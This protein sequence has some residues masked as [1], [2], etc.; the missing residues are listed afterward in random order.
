MLR[1]VLLSYLI[2]SCPNAYLFGRWFGGRDVRRVGSRNVGATNVVANVGWLA[3]A[4]TL[5]G[6]LGKGYLA[7]L[8][9]GPSAD[10]VV[11][12]LA[13]AFAIAG[14]N[15]PVW[16]GFHGGGGLATFVGACLRLNGW[17][18]AVAAL[19]LWGLV[20]A[21]IR[22]HDKS[23]VVA[24][25][26]LPCAV[27]VAQQSLETFTFIASSSLAV[28]LRRVQ[29]IKERIGRMREGSRAE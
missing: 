10:S 25:V 22:D 24:C 18:M 20:Y 28:L 16:L 23:A 2:G 7:A 4:L 27:F 13:P 21:L 29:S 15:W 1:S 11:S 3:G 17:P 12:F 19:V 9:G 5:I 14:H 6:D 8:V 26:V